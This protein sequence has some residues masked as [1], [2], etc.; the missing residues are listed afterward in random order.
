MSTVNDILTATLARAAAIEGVTTAIKRSRQF[1]DEELPAV[2]VHREATEKAAEARGLLGGIYQV[3][4]TVA[5]EY[6]KLAETEDPSAEAEQ[7][8]I[9]VIQAVELPE[10]LY[11]E[12]TW[13]PLTWERDEVAL[14]DAA[15]QAIAV[16]VTFITRFHRGYGAP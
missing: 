5:V 7:M 6:H 15:G 14:P 2:A 16:E 8:V 11:Q 3:E 10:E 9:D 4:V 1:R 13:E 12:F